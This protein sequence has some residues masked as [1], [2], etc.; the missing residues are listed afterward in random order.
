MNSLS[1][2]KEIYN[3]RE[4][5]A[6]LIRR[7]L[8]GRYKGSALGFLWTFLNPLLQLV[9]FTVVFST[10][11][12]MGIQRYYLFLF[13][14]QIPWGFF[15]SSITAG[16]SSVLAQGGMVTKIYFPREVL[17]IAFVTSQFIN[18]LYCFIVIFAVILVSGVG[19]NFQALLYLPLIMLIE[20]LLALGFAMFLS[21]LDIYCRDIEYTMGII[22]MM[23]MYLTPVFYPITMVP[24]Q[25]TPLLMLN[26][27]TSVITAYRDILYYTKVPD[28]ATLSHAVV[29]GI[30]CLCIGWFV[31]DKLSRRF[32][33]EL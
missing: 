12:R 29:M 30:V 14:A 19:F 31:F 13:V 27:M 26:P 32:A 23:W 18:M 2:I 10:I 9:V 20:Y 4:M 11:L 3:Y 33:E 17:P 1:R 7:D 21:A 6:M 15:S 28:I 24:A 5:I 8:R 25:Y 16:C 22:S